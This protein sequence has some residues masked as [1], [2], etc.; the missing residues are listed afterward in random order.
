MRKTRKI[1]FRLLGAGFA[2]ALAG[3]GMLAVDWLQIPGIIL[4][5]VGILLLIA[6][7]AHWWI[8]G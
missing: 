2:L 1:Y 6:A 7:Q 4:L 5:L 3:G 8:F